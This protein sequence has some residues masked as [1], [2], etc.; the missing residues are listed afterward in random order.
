MLRKLAREA[1][2]FFLLGAVLGIVGLGAQQV[3][4]YREYR[5][6]EIAYEKCIASLSV[7]A[8]PVTPKTESDERPGLS[9]IP[10]EVIA[11]SKCAVPFKPRFLPDN[12]RG[13]FVIGFRAGG[14][15]GLGIWIVYKL[16]RFGIKG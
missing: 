3:S 16:V 14:G 7:P 1:V 9:P 10:E 4:E 13:I 15:A 5:E 11:R 6:A 2:I 12:W 8:R